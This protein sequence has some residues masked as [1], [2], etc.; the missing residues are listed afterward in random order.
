MS[1]RHDAIYY[2][3]LEEGACFLAET[4]T[5]PA[6]RAEHLKMAGIYGRQAR[7]AG[8]ILSTSIH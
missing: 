2:A 7:D 8:A 6:A 5:D 3:E 4:A 1:D